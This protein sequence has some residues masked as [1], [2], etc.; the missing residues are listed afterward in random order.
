MNRRKFIHNM[1]L[2]LASISLLKTSCWQQDEQSKPNIIFIMADD[3][4]YG[5][6]G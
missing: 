2:S 3:L 4:G 6:L 1:G 5:D